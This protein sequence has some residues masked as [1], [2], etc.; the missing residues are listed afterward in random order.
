LLV[1]TYLENSNIPKRYLS[2]I[3]LRPCQSD[4]QSFMELNQIKTNIKDFVANGNNLLIY[5]SH[6]GNGKTTWATKILVEYI[7]SIGRVI[8][9]DNCP[10]LFINVSNF[11]NKKKIAISDL[12][13]A[14]EVR[15]IEKQIISAN[16]VVFDDLGVK[17]ITPYEMNSLYYWI[18]ERTSNLKSCIFTSNLSPKIL[19]TV[20]DPRVYSRVINYSVLKEITGGDNRV[21]TSSNNK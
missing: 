19:E 11:L 16:L 10:G 9:K 15:M 12:S 6:T 14:D 17:D 3:K 18:D 7:K 4:E 21:S 8:F 1:D 5:S 13:L 2:D 20:L